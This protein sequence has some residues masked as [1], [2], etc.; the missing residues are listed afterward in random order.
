MGS[1]TS[2]ILLKFGE[3]KFGEENNMCAND[4]E[5]SFRK[6]FSSI[7]KIPHGKYEFAE[8]DNSLLKDFGASLKTHFDF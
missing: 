1:M 3:I 6:Y 7:E 8:F 2:D 5:S 4:Y